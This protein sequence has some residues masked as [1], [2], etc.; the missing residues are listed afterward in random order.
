VG[1]TNTDNDDND[2]GRAIRLDLDS[3]TKDRLIL[4]LLAIIFGGSTSIG[5]T[6]FLPPPEDLVRPDKYTATMAEKA[7]KAIGNYIDAEI[8]DV[9]GD[10]ERHAAEVAKLNER[11]R[12]IERLCERR[13]VQIESMMRGFDH[14]HR[15]GQ[16]GH[17]EPR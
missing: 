9:R 12:D 14:S 2:S 4:A 10:L 6:N 13:S 5:I 7:Q 11:V 1:G 15:S 16:N 17:L 3:L 8:E